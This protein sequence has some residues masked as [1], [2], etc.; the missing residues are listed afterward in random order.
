MQALSSIM[1][2]ITCTLLILAVLIQN[3]KGGGISSNFKV[4]T[5][6]IGARRG[7]QLIEKATWT[8]AI[9]FLVF[10]VLYKF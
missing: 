9:L 4:A 5:Q 6:V 1:I 3:S 8:L 7:T 10:T 2:I